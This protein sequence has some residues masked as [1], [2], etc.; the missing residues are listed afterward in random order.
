MRTTIRALAGVVLLALAAAA[1][2]TEGGGNSY[3]VGVETQMVGM[4]P[5]EGNHFFVYY[6]HYHARHQKDH[7]GRDNAALPY[8]RLKADVIALRWSHIWRGV[9]IFG[10][11][12]ETR[13][14][15]SPAWTSRSELPAR[16][17]WVR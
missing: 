1:S 11:S 5:P 17:H 3:P 13:L 15:P 4:M 8:F 12:V 10:A 16:R 7:A 9:R 14:S 6:Q 2:A